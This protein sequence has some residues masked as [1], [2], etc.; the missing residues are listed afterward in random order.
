MKAFVIAGAPGA[1]KSTYAEKLARDENAT[2]ISG[3]LL[4]TELYGDSEDYPSWSEIWSHIE[5][6]VTENV[7]LP[8]IMDGTHCRKDYRAEVLTLLRSYG[9][10]EVEAIILYTPLAICL[11]RNSQRKRVVPEHTVR[12]MFDSLEKSLSGLHKETFDH[13]TI[14][15]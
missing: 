7:G 3:D 10:T 13:V 5:D 8:L 4:R 11:E 15:A 6:K 14:I 12:H 2:I 1:G 9:Y